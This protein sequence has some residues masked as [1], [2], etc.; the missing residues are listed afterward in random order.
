MF[1]KQSLAVKIITIIAYIVLLTSIFIAWQGWYFP[2]PQYTAT[3]YAQ[4]IAQE[5]GMSMKNIIINL[6]IFFLPMYVI[7]FLFKASLKRFSWWRIFL[8]G[9]IALLFSVFF[10]VRA[11][12]ESLSLWY[13]LEKATH[14][15]ERKVFTRGMDGG[16]GLQKE[17][18]IHFSVKTSNLLF[19]QNQIAPNLQLLGY[20]VESFGVQIRGKR[21]IMQSNQKNKDNAVQNIYNTPL[22]N[23]LLNGDGAVI[24]F[25]KDPKNTIYFV[26]ESYQENNTIEGFL[27][28]RY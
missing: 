9:T 19:I 22:Q 21:Y 17:Y 2:K 23:I 4:V 8:V 24:N 5:F 26:T 7:S 13:P 11:V 15:I 28:S 20:S 12:T 25:Q 6:A 3:S 10:V 16:L 14:N 18:T 1:E 27:Q